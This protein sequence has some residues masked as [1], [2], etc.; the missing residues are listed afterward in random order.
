MENKYCIHCLP[1]KRRTHLHARIDFMVD[2]MLVPFEAVSRF[3]AR[4]PMRNLSSLAGRG[5]VFVLSKLTVIRLARDVDEEK[6]LNRSLIFFREAQRRQLDVRALTF[7]G[8]PMNEYVLFANGRRHHYECIPLKIRDPLIVNVDDKFRMKKLLADHAVPVAEGKRFYT[9]RRAYNYGMHLGFPLVVKPNG[10]SL[11]CHTFVDIN[12][13]EELAR[14]I[15]D[16]RAYRPD[17]IVERFIRGPLY[18]ATVI[19]QRKVYVCRRDR[20]NVVGDGDSTIRQLV[21]IKNADERRGKRG[22][23]NVTL[24]EIPLDDVLERQLAQQALNLDSVPDVGQVVLLQPKHILSQGADVVNVIDD[25]HPENI[26]LFLDIARLLQTNLVGIDFICPEVNQPHTG[27]ECA[28]LEANSL[29]Y[30]DMHAFPSHGRPEPVASD[31]WDIVLEDLE[32]TD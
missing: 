18:R 19:G 29:P 4:T 8:R 21:E 32:N 30:I 12:S 2:H 13:E 24:F 10:G 7:F 20:A 1:T 5:A 25:V 22:Q 6:I 14:A 15:R 31:A 16:C 28:V 9:A 23:P 17:I 26:Q 3:A 27:Q 11:S